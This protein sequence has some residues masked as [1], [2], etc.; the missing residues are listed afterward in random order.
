MKESK[1]HIQSKPGFFAFFFLHLITEEKLQ[2]FKV[3][4]KKKKN[5]VRN[6]FIVIVHFT[7]QLLH[8]ADA[9]KI[10]CNSF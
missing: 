1:L 7:M 4:L 10:P 9:V 2:F 6:L 5:D 3:K 8:Y